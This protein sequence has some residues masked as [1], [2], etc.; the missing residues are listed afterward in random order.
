M[1]SAAVAL[2]LPARAAALPPGAHV[3]V[4]KGGLNFPVDM[5]Y[6]PNSH[7]LFFTE[8]NTGAIRVIL[9]GQLLPT[10]CVDLDVVNDGERG[11]LGLVLDPHYP[12]NHFIYVYFTKRSPLENRVTRFTVRDNRCINAHPI[13]TGIPSVSGYHNGGQLLF[14][15]GMLYVTVGEGHDAANAQRLNTRLGKVLRY[16]PNGTIPADNPVLGGRRSAIW[17][18]GHRNGFGLVRKPGTN[19]LYESENGPNCDDEVNRI[20]RGRNYG[21]GN[22]YVCGTNGVGPNPVAPMKRWT[23]TIAPTDPWWYGGS[24]KA[25]RGSIY[26]GD[27]NTGT[28]RRITLNQ[29]GTAVRSIGVTYRAPSGIMDVSSG[30]GGWLYF[31]T[32]TAIYRIV[33]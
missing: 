20:M 31:C 26:L 14:L 32:Q 12:Q 8:K 4:F 7:K 19:L 23:P 29:N 24:V 1:A 28:L 10:P 13:I 27:F 25:L 30:P 6:V 11:A 9:N 22:G 5:A 18:Y 15:R 17:S 33:S 21:W 16:N 3:Q 2:L